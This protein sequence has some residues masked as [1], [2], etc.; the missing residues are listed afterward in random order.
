MSEQVAQLAARADRPVVIAVKYAGFA[1]VATGCNLGSQALMD[2][3]YQGRLAVYASLFVGTLVG[4]VVKYL[5]DKKFI[6]YDVTQGLVRRGWQFARYA[7]TGI[8]TTAVFWGLE[9]GAYHAFHAQA[10]RYVG[11]AV[12]LAIGY[13]LKYQLD[14][15]LVFSG[16]HGATPTGTV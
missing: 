5:L 8:L 15:R 7:L 13:W 4:L 10:A 12:G 2:G 11:G 16:R 14:K 9:L 3:A 6:F 1:G